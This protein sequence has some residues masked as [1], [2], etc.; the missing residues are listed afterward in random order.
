MAYRTGDTAAQSL[1]KIQQRFFHNGDEFYVEVFERGMAN[2]IYSVY[3]GQI[4]NTS[5]KLPEVEPLQ[6]ILNQWANSGFVE[7]MTAQEFL[8]RTLA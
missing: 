1:A 5:N 2:K 4:D 7:S 8:N 6:R 3:V